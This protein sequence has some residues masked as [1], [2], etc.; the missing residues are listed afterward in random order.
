MMVSTRL[1]AAVVALLALPGFVYA[2]ASIAGT[3]RDT[4]GAVLPGVTVEA[5][6]AALIERVRVAVTDNSGQYRIVDLRPGTYVV[7]F[8]LP[9]FSSVRRDGVELTGAFNATVNADLRVGALE[10]TITVTGEAP[11]V[12]VQ[13]AGRTEVIDKD[14]I[15]AIPS[16]RTPFSIAGLIPSVNYNA[17]GG[18]GP[19]IG[20]TNA[21]SLARLT[22]HGGREGD[23]RTNVDGLSTNNAEGSGQFAAW[24]PNMSSAQEITFD[25]SGGS[26]ERPTGGVFVNVIPREGGNV[27]SGTFFAN[28]T[29]GWQS[30]NYDADLEARGFPTP[31]DIQ[32]L[33]DVN[34][35]FGGPLLVDRLWFFSAAR[36]QVQNIYAGGFENANAGNPNVWEYAPDPSRRT[37]NPGIQHGI[38]GRV[39]WQV[40]QRHKVSLYYDQQ[41]RCLCPRNL[42]ALNSPE[43]VSAFENPYTEFSTATWSAPLTN[44]LLVDAGWS[45]HPEKWQYPRH[46]T[47]MIGVLEQSTGREYRGQLQTNQG[48]LFP[49]APEVVENGRAA[50]SYVTGT[51]AYKAGVQYQYQ[52]RRI[53]VTDNDFNL[54]YRFNN[55][56]PNQLTQR[57]TPFRTEVVS[58]AGLGLF[59]QDRWTANRLTLNLGLRYDYFPTYF[60]EQHFGPSQYVPT[61]DVTFP[62]TSWASMHDLTPR[63]GAVYDLRGDGRTALRVSVNKYV[64]GGELNGIAGSQSNPA[65]LA[66]NTVTRAW[67]DTNRDYV[68]DCDLTNTLAN[69]ECGRVS[70]LSFGKTG[71]ASTRVDPDVVRGWGVRPYNWEFSGGIQRQLM[72]GLSL[73][74]AYFRRIYGNFYVTDNLAVGS[75]DFSAFSITAPSDARLPGGGGQVISGLFDLNED[76]VGQVN[77]LVT[78][79]NQYGTR[80]EHWNGVDVTINTRLRQGIIL[81][82]GM[83][84]GRTVED[85]CDI[86]AALPESAPTNP[87]CH[88]QG[89]WL[90]SYKGFGSY[91]VPKAEVQVS[92]TFQ[93]TPGPDI[94]PGY[95]A[96]SAE[97]QTSLGRPLS[98][99]ARNKTINLVQPSS[100]YGDRVYNVDLRLGKLIT[101]R[102]ARAS[103]NVDVYNLFNVNPV[104][105]YNTSYANWLQPTRVWQA[106]FVKLGVQFDF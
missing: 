43:S 54:S 28:G 63:F 77:N 69:G 31:N 91:V 99:G 96:S 60:P 61:R 73:D 87:Y 37:V 36:R 32:R 51:H 39:T 70:D 44:R 100:L 82:G 8:S 64:G 92:V 11:I 62:R 66:V 52:S 76:R 6:S 105:S 67:N 98:G 34:G 104:A 106:R 18:P 83:S 24:M 23:M 55:G 49:E 22:S 50:V 10:E 75:D 30:S 27:F 102:G 45:H 48:G 16:S 101:I 3:V 19:D 72:T 38:N 35:G 86:R 90:T 33:Y 15:D 57:T 9:G 41:Y 78:N 84:T 47:N 42:T 59:V 46:D 21:V 68:P 26:A 20:G 80:I 12:D 40:S 25:I 58:P 13:S 7:S 93:S 53:S 94:A 81:Q 85:S 5:A 29:D 2:Q 56:I 4:S 17:P 65:N 71:I 79:A 14:T 97:I 89:A 103:L 1:A 74:V 95:V 88:V